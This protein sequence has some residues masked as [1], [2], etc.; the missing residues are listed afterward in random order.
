MIRSV[1]LMKAGLVLCGFLACQSSL[2]AS[3]SI[4]ISQVYG[5]GGTVGAVYKNDFIELHNNG[6]TTVNL[7]GWTVQY[8]DVNSNI[9]QEAFL[10][11][12]SS[13][14]PGQYFLIAGAQG[15]GGSLDLPAPNASSPTI[16]LSATSGKV[17]LVNNGTLLSGSCPTGPQIIDFVGYGS[18]NCSEGNAAP[19]PGNTTAIL[20][21]ANGCNDTDN[22]AADFVVGAPN[23]RNTASA[24]NICQSASPLFVSWAETAT[25]TFAFQ[26]TA[27]PTR[28]NTVQFSSNLS[29]W[30]PLTASLSHAGNLYSCVD[31]N[32]T[33]SRFYRVLSQ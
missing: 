25:G 12:F 29:S 21:T 14:G 22:N 16:N 20:R 8:L 32:A 6:N 27:D 5:G 10:G 33:R 26:F 4:V 15:A 30:L 24:A 11:G 9:W 17:A 2:A 31:T 23:P 7:N 18:A 19:A 3:T 13:M 28:S 1:I